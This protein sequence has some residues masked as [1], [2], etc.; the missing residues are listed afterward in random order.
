VKFIQRTRNFQSFFFFP[1]FPS[2]ELFDLRRFVSQLGVR[3]RDCEGVWDCNRD[4][5]R[6]CK[7]ERDLARVE[8]SVPVA[9]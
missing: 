5:E 7:R 4:R 8:A 1:F 2:F 9:S 3:E 6:E